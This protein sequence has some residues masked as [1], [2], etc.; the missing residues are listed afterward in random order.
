MPGHCNIFYLPDGPENYI[1]N[2]EIK[3]TLEFFQV[4]LHGCMVQKFTDEFFIL[5]VII[6]KAATHAKE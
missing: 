1:K 5:A 2:S 4:I 6:F 3:W